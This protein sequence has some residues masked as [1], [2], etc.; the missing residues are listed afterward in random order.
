MSTTLTDRYEL[1]PAMLGTTFRHL[2]P[3][4]D[5]VSMNTVA[6]ALRAAD[7]EDWATSDESF[8]AFYD[9]LVNCDPA[10]DVMVVE[11]QAMVIAY[12][13]AAWLEELD[14]LRTY[15]PISF[16]DP[17][18]TDAI[19]LRRSIIETM[20]TRCRQMAATHPASPKSFQLSAADSATDYAALIL[21]L[22]YSQE[23]YF[24]TMV[25]PNLGDL[26][27]MPL[28]AGLEV[29]EVEPQHLRAIWEAEMEALG[30]HW[31]AP[32][33]TEELY[34]EFLHSPDQMDTSL[35][36]IA[37]D[38]DQIAGMV[39]SYINPEENERYGRKRGWVEN[40][41]VR[42][43]WRRRGLARALIAASIPLLR[44]RGMTEGA[45]GVDT[46]N[47]SGALRV[48]EDCGFVAVKRETT[49]RRR[50]E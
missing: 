30:D 18:A 26:P 6:N 50:L 39:R 47:P 38:G 42:R 36:R 25:R 10:T 41:M 31:G 32:V 9:H 35:W 49:Y 5:Y 7:G 23:R 17:D 4:D 19:V 15:E 37:W 2:R 43:Q 1:A 34:Q 29:R 40:I 45:L 3:P 27:G 44:A 22:G 13:R 46:E 21:E 12:G 48:Y 24:Y 14:G 20:E 28:P 11:R 16:V 8:R 33:P